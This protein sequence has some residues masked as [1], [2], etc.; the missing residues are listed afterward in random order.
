MRERGQM[1][2]PD[3][4]VNLAD[5][6]SR[7]DE[8]WSPRI[9]AQL[10]DL[11]IKLAKL[12]GAFVWHHHDDTDEMFVVIDGEL[13]IEMPDRAVQLGPGELFVVPSGVEHRP[14]TGVRWLR[15]HAHRA[16]WRGQHRFRR[17]SP[18][19]HGRRCRR[20]DLIVI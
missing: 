16:G 10:N 11:H 1:A 8:H 7:F 19:R 14:V 9:V 4:V 15:G 12:D 3:A 18:R 2:A 13:T 5:K 17:G 20:V 6:L